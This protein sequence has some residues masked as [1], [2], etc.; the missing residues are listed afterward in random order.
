MSPDRHPADDPDD[1]N[2]GLDVDA[3]FAEIVARWE[4]PT[5]DPA[6]QSDEDVTGSDPESADDG[7]PQQ[8]AGLDPGPDTGS[9]AGPGTE[10]DTGPRTGPGPDMARLSRLFGA[11]EEPTSPGRAAESD[12]DHFVPPPPPP[13][14][15]LEPRR[16]LAWGGLLGTPLVALLMAGAGL[17]PPGWVAMIL[18]ICFVGGF[19]YLVA[20]M[21]SR[22][23]DGPDDGAVI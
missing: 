5:P 9:G 16:K 2:R 12:D 7:T 10:P 4:G 13:L 19:G 17:R 14:P 22:R 18:V 3:A 23:H 21:P 8:S 1:P 15:V 20:T 11:S 6:L